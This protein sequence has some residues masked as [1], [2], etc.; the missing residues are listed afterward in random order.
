MNLLQRT[1]SECMHLGICLLWCCRLYVK[2]ALIRVLGA[3][4]LTSKYLCDTFFVTQCRLLLPANKYRVP[5]FSFG[6][7]I[8]FNF[9]RLWCFCVYWTVLQNCIESYRKL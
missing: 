3:V 9:Q 1:F 2:I 4:F 5:G 8:F 6:T 7:M